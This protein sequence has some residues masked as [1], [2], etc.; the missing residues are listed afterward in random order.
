MEREGEGDDR[1]VL[2]LRAIFHGLFGWWD[3]CIF[4]GKE[5]SF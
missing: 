3:F 2:Y 5:G 1:G 4:G